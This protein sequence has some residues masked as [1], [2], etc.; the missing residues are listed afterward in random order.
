MQTF[1][2]VR[3]EQAFGGKSLL[4]QGGTYL[5]TGGLGGIALALAEHLAKDFQAKLVLVSRQ[6]LPPKECLG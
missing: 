6:G 2:P 5:I 4:R 3:F 1:A